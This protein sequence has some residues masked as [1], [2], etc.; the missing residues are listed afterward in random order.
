MSS[1]IVLPLVGGVLIGLSASLLLLAHGRVAGI[2]GVVG[3]MLGP[4]RG[5]AAWRVLFLGGLLTGGLV[6]AWLRPGGLPASV[7]LSLGHL[8]LLGGAGLLV[9]FGSQLG[10]G[11]TSGHGVCGI[12]R[13]S[14]RSI[15]ATLTFMATGALTVFFVRHVF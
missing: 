14:V 10:N 8:S 4:I 7:P 9:G 3:A 15:V 6:L 5:D 13:G 2:S 11:C 1:S 12:S